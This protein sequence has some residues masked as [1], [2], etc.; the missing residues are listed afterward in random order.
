MP[1]LAFLLLG[2]PLLPGCRD[3]LPP[4]TSGTVEIRISEG[5]AGAAAGARIYRDGDIWID[6]VDDDSYSGILPAGTYT[7]R[8]EK[9]CT[10]ILPAPEQTVEVD[11]TGHYTLAWNVDVNG[12]LLVE[13]SLPGSPIFLDG[14]DTGRMT[15]TTLECLEPGTREV[16]VGAMV[17]F[18]NAEPEPKMVEVDEG[19][20]TVFFDY[21]GP[22]DQSRGAVV[23]VL[24][25]VNCPNCL[26]VDEAVERLWDEP[27]FPEAGIVS[28]QLHHPWSGSDILRT[29]GTE[30]RNTFY[31]FP[32]NNSG[33]PATRTNGMFQTAGFPSGQTEDG[34]YSDTLERIEPF[35]SGDR[36]ESLV[37][38]YWLDTDFDPATHMASARMRVIC[39]DDIPTPADTRV[40]GMVYKNALTTFSA[41]HRRD[42]EFYRVVRDLLDVGTCEALGLVQRGDWTDVEFVYDLSNDVQWSEDEMGVVGLVQDFGTRE[43]FN[44]RHT[45]LP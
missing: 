43:I 29:D 31:G 19:V 2:I 30:S 14:V 10:T 24:T 39:L 5:S 1:L 33:L 21:G 17:G 36:S 40:L 34:F 13:S 7:F 23:E 37:A 32:P 22:I 20:A 44:V 6:P 38:L 15:P 27:G 16:R 18:S 45:F 3:E 26:P 9:D 42:V 25:A 35:L 28:L 41:V 12:G 4:P 11:P 8:M